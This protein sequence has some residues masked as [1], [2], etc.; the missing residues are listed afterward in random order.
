[1]KILG[2]GL[3]SSEAAILAALV[4]SLPVLAVITGNDVTRP[5]IVF[6]V[7]LCAWGF[8]ESAI[9]IRHWYWNRQG[10]SVL[11]WIALALSTNAIALALPGNSPIYLIYIW[12]PTLVGLLVGIRLPGRRR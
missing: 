2:G 1:M 3:K 11:A 4:A 8:A 10:W 5:A 6:V 12:A 7:I 9:G